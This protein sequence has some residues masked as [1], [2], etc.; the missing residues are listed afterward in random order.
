MLVIVT[1]SGA[2]PVSGA[3]IGTFIINEVISPNS[4]QISNPSGFSQNPATGAINIISSVIAKSNPNPN[5]I[6]VGYCDKAGI[7]NVIRQ[8]K[9]GFWSQLLK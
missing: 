7:L 4:I 3:N 6:I 9:I 8:P 2:T 1:A 5:D